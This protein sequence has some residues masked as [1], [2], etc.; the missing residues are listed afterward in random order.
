MWGRSHVHCWFVPWR[1]CWWRSGA[2]W[3]VC[4]WASPEEQLCFPPWR[5]NEEVSLRSEETTHSQYQRTG[6]FCVKMSAHLS[7]DGGDVSVM[8]HQDLDDAGVLVRLVAPELS[9]QVQWRL[10]LLQGAPNT[11]K[12]A[13]FYLVLLRYI[14]SIS[15]I[16]ESD[17]VPFTHTELRLLTAPLIG[18]RV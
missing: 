15:L 4:Y 7:G 18:Q 5:C 1:V 12:H 8:L 11:S 17:L 3:R 14:M 9:C 6:Q 10:A 13:G 2:G 16:C